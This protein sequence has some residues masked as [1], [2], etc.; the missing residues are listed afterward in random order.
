L[1]KDVAVSEFFLPEP[2]D[3]WE[4]CWGAIRDYELYVCI[5]LR[6]ST[7]DIVAGIRS[8]L[9]KRREDERRRISLYP[10]YITV[11]DL[12]QKGKTA[13]EIAP[14]LWPDENATKGGRGPYGDKG[15]LIQRV[16]DYEAA[17]NDLIEKSFPAKQRQPKIQK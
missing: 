1:H 14:K 5:D 7:K 10:E 3:Y 13:D 6:H 17:A 2:E 4:G 15:T 9:S 16:Y 11:W 12:R 8:I